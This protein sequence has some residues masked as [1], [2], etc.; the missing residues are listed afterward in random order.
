MA[1]GAIVAFYF[2]SEK[3]YI[4]VEQSLE[5]SKARQQAAATN[6]TAVMEMQIVLQAL[7]AADNKT[8]IRK[9]AIASL[10]SSAVID[11]QLQGLKLAIPE[12]ATVQSLEKDLTNIKPSQMKI[13]G[14]AKKNKDEEALTVFKGVEPTINAIAEK[15][16]EILISEQLLLSQ[17]AVKNRE[18]GR[19]ILIYI[20]IGLVCGAFVNFLIAAIFSKQLMQSINRIRSSMKD[21]STGELTPNIDTD[22]TGELVHINSDFALSVTNVRNVI[23][24][25]SQEANLILDE[26]HSLAENSSSSLQDTENVLHLIITMTKKSDTLLTIS[27]ETK[28]KLSECTNITDLSE[29]ASQK[30]ANILNDSRSQFNELQLA[31]TELEV[32]SKQLSSSATEIH[33]ITSSI[34]SIS[35]QTNLLALNAAIEA[36][37]AGEQGRGFAVVADEVRSL[38]KRSGEATEQVGSIT[39]T[40]NTLVTTTVTKLTQATELINESLERMDTACTASTDSKTLA[41]QCNAIITDVMDATHQ[42][43]ENLAAITEESKLISTNLEKSKEQVSQLNDL[44][45]KLENTAERMTTY[46]KHFKN[47]S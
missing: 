37:R 9:F 24:G 1:F 31:M 47:I 23:S 22:S 8:D 28:N 11:E 6:L 34:R 27:R 30:S 41:H 35:E 36:A 40:M 4:H 2:A 46:V 5:E 10:K 20:A 7:I 17:L 26:S 45:F 21:F 18:Y 32:T 19:T 16:R 42:E 29:K 44:S 38:A 15:S 25:I 12:S 39:E 13:I 43:L 33:S 14:F 3:Q